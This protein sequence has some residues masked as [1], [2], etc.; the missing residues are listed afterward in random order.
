VHGVGC[1]VNVTGGEMRTKKRC[2]VGC[3]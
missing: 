2:G 1:G 3:V